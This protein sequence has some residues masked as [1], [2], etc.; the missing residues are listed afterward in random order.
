MTLAYHI[1]R[2]PHLRGVGLSK[3]MNWTGRRFPSDDEA[4]K[5][6]HKDAAGRPYTIDRKTIT[7]ELKPCSRT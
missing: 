6:A 1:T 2:H 3:V 4:A 7:R 5:F